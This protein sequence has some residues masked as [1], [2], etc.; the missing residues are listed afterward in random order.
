M[1]GRRWTLKDAQEAIA[2]WYEELR[3]AYNE[4]NWKRIGELY[5]DDSLVY[6]RKSG[7]TAV[8]KAKIKG[9][10]KDFIKPKKG[11]WVE[12]KPVTLTLIPTDRLVRDGLAFERIMQLVHW[13]AVLVFQK[14]ES[15]KDLGMGGHIEECVFNYPDYEEMT[16]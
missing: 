10:W 14:K 15:V 4:N 8:G 13:E 2:A 9:L 11:T 5:N 12:T 1:I 3:K 6:A 7:K 16:I